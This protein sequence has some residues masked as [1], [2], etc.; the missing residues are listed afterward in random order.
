MSRPK[1]ARLKVIASTVVTCPVIVLS[2]VSLSADTTTNF[3]LWGLERF[4][5]ELVQFLETCKQ[6]SGIGTEQLAEYP[7]KAFF[8]FVT[9]E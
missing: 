1:M 8:V 9:D 3:S 2:I 7:F 4:F 6:Q 5:E